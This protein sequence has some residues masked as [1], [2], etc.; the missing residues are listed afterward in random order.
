MLHYVEPWLSE[1]DIDAGERWAQAI[2]KELEASKFGIICV[3]RDNIA[4][5]WILFEAGA[6]AKS[7]V[8]S[9]VIPIL[10]DLEFRDITGPLAQFQAKKAEKA[11]L[12]EV[13][14]SI[15]QA[16]GNSVPEAR[17]KQLYDALWP[18]LEEK[19]SAIPK[20]TSAVK[21]TRPQHDVL[22]ELVAGVRALDSRLRE[23]PVDP[24][25]SPR[26]RRRFHSFMLHELVMATGEKP[27]GPTSI[28]V[29]ASLF[30]ETAPWIYELGLDA[31]RTAKHGGTKD[32]AQAIRRFRRAVEVTLHGPIPAEEL[33]ID[34]R[35]LDM[36]FH[37]L[38]LTLFEGPSESDVV[39]PSEVVSS[40]PL[41]AP[42]APSP[43]VHPN[44]HDPKPKRRR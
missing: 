2:A 27:G 44:E 13:V 4:S 40:P 6:L 31:F 5:P 15:N 22:E 30:R 11:G 36:M 28:L 29:F 16:A 19:L 32:S 23:Q 26:H 41:P 20:Q 9:R 7:M 8:D 25:R 34:P 21:H 38:Q 1:A 12:S 24:I 43:A 35:M 3:T 17:A 37:D 42:V 33:G 18:Q 14:H 39:A 10:L